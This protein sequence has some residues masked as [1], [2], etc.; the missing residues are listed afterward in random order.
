MPAVPRVTD[1]K[2]AVAAALDRLARLHPK[3]IDLSLNRLH[4]LLAALGNPE[5]RLPPVI[6]VAGT[7]GKGSTL[8]FQ[9]AMLEAT[10]RKVH[11]YTS[12]HLVRFNE[13]IVLAGAE[14]S[15]VRLADVL[16]RCEAANGDAPIT[17]FEVTTAAAF[18]AFA[19]TP[20]DIVLLEVGLGGRLDATNV[21]AAPQV[22]AITR[23][24]TDHTEFLGDTIAKIAAEKAGI[25][26]AGVPLVVG[27][28]TDPAVVDTICA[29]AEDVGAPVHVGGRD[30]TIEQQGDGFAVHLDGRSIQSPSPGLPGAHQ[31]D[32]AATAIA[33][34]GFVLSDAGLADAISGI[35]SARWPA[36]LQRLTTGPLVD[37]VPEGTAVWLDGGHNDSAGAALAAWLANRSQR[38]VAVIVGMLSTK[39]PAEFLR[40]L[41][42][43][44]DHLIAVPVQ[45]SAAGLAPG[46]LA[47]AAEQ[48]GFRQA[49]TAASPL[50]GLRALGAAGE[51]ATI[52]ICGSLY[53][54]GEVLQENC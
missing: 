50:A 40:P 6:H 38:P 37:A 19:E 14:I 20:A 53:L 26:K 22:T 11:A 7:N 4:R 43:H 45:E 15:D 41:G 5:R 18:L 48:A 44:A 51:F 34:L 33:S 16:D 31:I 27:P 42:G 30:W 2:A 23:V 32:N 47:L 39:D 35:A 10:G 25:A 13:R 8:A 54:A 12:P 28:Q 29:R 49:G 1:P 9:R 52:L 21:V 36:R 24:S 46:A 17:F 3:R